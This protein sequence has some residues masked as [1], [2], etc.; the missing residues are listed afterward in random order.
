MRVFT[1]AFCTF[2]NTFSLVII[3]PMVAFMVASFYPELEKSELGWRASYFGR[4]VQF[5]SAFWLNALWMAQ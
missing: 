4:G 2:G 3:Y 1:A 5:W